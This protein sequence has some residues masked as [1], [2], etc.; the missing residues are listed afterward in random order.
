M[1]E[2]SIKHQES[3]NPPLLIADVRQRYLVSEV[4]FVEIKN[5]KIMD[6]RGAEIS[7]EFI[8]QHEHYLGKGW[9]YVI[10]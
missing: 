3:T 7:T 2:K 5:G 10:L 8:L 9:G 4:I 1:S 6:K